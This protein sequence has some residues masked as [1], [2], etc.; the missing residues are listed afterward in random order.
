MEIKNIRRYFSR[1]WLNSWEMGSNEELSPY[2]IDSFEEK[3]WTYQFWRFNMTIHC[4]EGSP[5]PAWVKMSID[6]HHDYIV[7]IEYQCDKQSIYNEIS[8]KN[9]TLKI[10]KHDIMWLVA[11]T[12]RKTSSSY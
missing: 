4:H 10:V 5:D 11:V 6:P 12:K 9:P 8:N 3:P 2:T 1:T 7:S